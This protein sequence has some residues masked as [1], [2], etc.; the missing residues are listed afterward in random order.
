MQY[1]LYTLL[2]FDSR[3][4]A[5]PVAWI[6]SRSISKHDVSK[7]MKALVDRVQASDASWRAGSFIIDDPAS[8]LDPIR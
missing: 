5:L 2:V 8:E 1:P 3:S 7:W 6:I 4:H